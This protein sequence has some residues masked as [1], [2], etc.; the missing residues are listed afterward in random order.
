MTSDLGWRKIGSVSSLNVTRGSYPHFRASVAC[1][2]FPPP[3]RSESGDGITIVHGD[4]RQEKPGGGRFYLAEYADSC[5]SLPGGQLATVRSPQSFPLLPGAA[6]QGVSSLVRLKLP[7]GKSTSFVVHPSI[8]SIRHIVGAQ[9]IFV[10]H[11]NSFSMALPWGQQ[12][13]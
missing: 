12:P 9:D 10:K 11:L 1:S 7:E 13:S 2:A 5:I 8:P 4:A 6:A 3:P